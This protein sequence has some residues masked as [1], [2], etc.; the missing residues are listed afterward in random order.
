MESEKKGNSLKVILIVI[1]A[2]IWFNVLQNAGIIPTS[3]KVSVTNKVNVGGEVSVAGV[4]ETHLADTVNVNL[5]K[6]NGRVAKSYYNGHL[7][8][9]VLELNNKDSKLKK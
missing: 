8:V 9:S 2:G 4:V 3:Q 6:I 5:S 7:G 1:A